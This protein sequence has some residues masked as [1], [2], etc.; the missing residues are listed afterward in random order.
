MNVSGISAALYPILLAL[1][2]IGL[3]VG[4]YDTGIPLL[5]LLLWVTGAL[6]IVGFLSSLIF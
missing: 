1:G 2:N 4:L 3:G 5:A 6:V